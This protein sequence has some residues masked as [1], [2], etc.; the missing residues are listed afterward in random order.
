M[1]TASPNPQSLARAP[2]DRAPAC[3][4]SGRSATQANTFSRRRGWKKYKKS[5]IPTASRPL[6]AFPFLP[7]PFLPLELLQPKERF[8]AGP[9]SEK[10]QPANQL[11]RSSTP[12]PKQHRPPERKSFAPHTTSEWCLL[13]KIQSPQLQPP[14]PFSATATQPNSNGKMKPRCETSWCETPHPVPHTSL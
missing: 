5:P 12:R 7:F 13:G 4:T 6:V 9:V 8:P 11:P 3:P 2:L 10:P 1:T 14:K